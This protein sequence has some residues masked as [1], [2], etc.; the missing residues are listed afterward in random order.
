MTM[1]KLIF[2]R[3]LENTYPFYFVYQRPERFDNATK[4]LEETSSNCESESESESGEDDPSDPPTDLTIPDPVPIVP[5]SYKP[6]PWSNCAI[7]GVCMAY[8]RCASVKVWGEPQYVINSQ[9]T[10]DRIQRRCQR[11]REEWKDKPRYGALPPKIVGT[12]G[13]DISQFFARLEFA[14]LEVEE[15]GKRLR[16]LTEREIKGV[17]VCVPVVRVSFDLSLAY[18]Q[19]NKI[20]DYYEELRALC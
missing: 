17:E 14:S 8:A 20:E 10:L 3:I 13:R 4:D 11:E 2:Q 15:T 9:A 5:S 12:K 7:N 1:S 18:G 16:P 19:L 6:F